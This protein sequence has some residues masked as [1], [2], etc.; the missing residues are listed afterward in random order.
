MKNL[1]RSKLLYAL[2]GVI[3]IAGYFIF[4]GGEEGEI[5]YV[6]QKIERGDIT[7]SLIHI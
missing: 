5:K 4:F 6:T 7:L 2:A 1:P 3:V